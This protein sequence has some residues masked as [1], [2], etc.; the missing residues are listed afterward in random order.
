MKFKIFALAVALLMPGMASAGNEEAAMKL[1]KKYNCLSCHTIDKKKVGPAW[2]DVAKKYADNAEARSFLLK[3]VKKGGKGVWG[4]MPMPA[5]PTV[6][7]KDLESLVDF[8]L[9]LK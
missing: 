3:K 4:T 9:A 2:R 1:A 8:V 5:N 7:K 6:K